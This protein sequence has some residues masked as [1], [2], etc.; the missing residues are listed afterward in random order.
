MPHKG[1]C[2][3]KAV[4]KIH[5]RFHF[6]A[7]HFLSLDMWKWLCRPVIVTY[8]AYDNAKISEW[9]QFGWTH[10][11]IIISVQLYEMA[12]HI[13]GGTWTLETISLKNRCNLWNC[14]NGQHT[15]PTNLVWTSIFK[16]KNIISKLIGI[17]FSGKKMSASAYHP[18]FW[19]A[20][21]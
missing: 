14:N 11:H 4:L 10:R 18:P 15:M 6:N 8:K 5:Q 1:R 7:V 2:L 20:D 3:E 21:P 17:N 16:L 12:W 19:I 9:C 13:S